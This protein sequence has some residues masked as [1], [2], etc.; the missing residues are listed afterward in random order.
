MHALMTGTS[1]GLQYIQLFY[2]IRV[3]YKMGSTVY[4]AQASNRWDIKFPGISA[5][6]KI[7]QKEPILFGKH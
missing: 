1:L 7:W 4:A 3:Y 2:Y 5:T 6:G